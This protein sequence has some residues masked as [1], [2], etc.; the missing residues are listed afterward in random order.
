MAS[1]PRVARQ[2]VSITQGATEEYSQLDSQYK[3][4]E[5]RRREVVG[6]QQPNG[7]QGQ[8]KNR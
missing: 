3:Q 2:V 5:S 4:Q 6:G 7:G 8:G 1:S